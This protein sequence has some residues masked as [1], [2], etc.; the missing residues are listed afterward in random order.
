M[1]GW[2]LSNAL[3]PIPGLPPGFL[4]ALFLVAALEDLAGAAWSQI[5]WTHGLP[6]SSARP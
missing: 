3:R 1:A 4:A 2:G 5:P 6:T